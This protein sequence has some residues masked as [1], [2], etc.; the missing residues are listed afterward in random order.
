MTLETLDFDN[1]TV[2][3][4][5][6]LSIPDILAVEPLLRA[7]FL[8]SPDYNPHY[9]TLEYILCTLISDTWEHCPYRP[10][11]PKDVCFSKNF[12][13]MRYVWDMWLTI[14]YVGKKLLHSKLDFTKHK[15]FKQQFPLTK[16]FRKDWEPQAHLRGEIW[17]RMWLML[18]R[19]HSFNRLLQKPA[20]LFYLLILEPS[21][22]MG[23]GLAFPGQTPDEMFN[24][25]ERIAFFQKQNAFLLNLDDDD[26]PFTPWTVAHLVTKTARAEANY[27]DRFRNQLYRPFVQSR[28][29]YIK[30]LKY[31]KPI[32]FSTDDNYSTVLSR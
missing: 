8:L 7:K 32:T 23:T 2:G 11:H 5:G 16:K 29:T 24:Q 13:V 14:E 18:E 6:N 9:E 27:S 28:M 31:S 12:A 4:V 21:G 17:C 3:D 10:K 15:W 25:A 30:T 20:T 22:L 19:L 26:D 1:L